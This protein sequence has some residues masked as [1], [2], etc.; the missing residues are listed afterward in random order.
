MKA[1]RGRVAAACA[2]A[3]CAMTFAACG[4]DDDDADRRT[5]V[6]EC[7]G[8]AHQEPTG[9]MARPQMVRALRSG[10]PMSDDGRW[11]Y[12]GFARL[13]RIADCGLR[14]VAG[15]DAV[16]ALEATGWRRIGRDRPGVDAV[17]TILAI[18]WSEKAPSGSTAPVF[19]VIARV[20]ARRRDG[21]LLAIRLR[22][23]PRT[24]AECAYLRTGGGPEPGIDP[25]VDP[26]RFAVPP[27]AG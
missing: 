2:A 3:L 11:R 21:R 18:D 6:D 23:E 27:E 5:V 22:C 25:R 7:D 1:A 13:V 4:S 9:G 17:G 14:D 19:R 24:L 10:E 12:E 20:V 8:Q 15:R 26:S 16:A